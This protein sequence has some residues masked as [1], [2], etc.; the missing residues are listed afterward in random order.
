MNGL[1]IISAFGFLWAC[2]KRSSFF[3]DFCWT[4][5]LAH[6]F[7]EMAELFFQVAVL[8]VFFKY[9][10]A[11]LTPVGEMSMAPFFMIMG[12]YLLKLLRGTTDF[13]LWQTA[14]IT[15]LYA[16]LMKSTT[17]S[18]FLIDLFSG[19]L[20]MAFICL[21]LLGMEKRLLFSKIPVGTKGL[22]LLMMNMVIILLALWGFQG[23]L[24]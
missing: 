23:I 17:L 11:P 8:Y 5:F 1:F 21:A 15:F 20:F 2:K 4:R 22:P 10:V 13:F 7:C 18:H 3:A 19:I 14:A 9:G 24:F 12:A 16:E 6:L